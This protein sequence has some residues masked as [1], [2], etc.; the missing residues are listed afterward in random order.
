MVGKE[1]PGKSGYGAPALQSKVATSDSVGPPPPRRAGKQPRGNRGRPGP[2]VHG[3]GNEATPKRSRRADTGSCSVLAL[4]PKAEA[5]WG[6]AGARRPGG[7]GGG[8]QRRLGLNICRFLRLVGLHVVLINF[9]R[10]CLPSASVISWHT[11]GPAEASLPGDPHAE[12]SIQMSPSAGFMRKSGGAISLLSPSRHVMIPQS[13]L[14]SSI[15]S[16]T[17]SAMPS[18][19]RPFNLG[20]SPAMLAYKSSNTKQSCRWLKVSI[21]T[22]NHKGVTSSPARCKKDAVGTVPHRACIVLRFAFFATFLLGR[23][24]LKGVQSMQS[25]RRRIPLLLPGR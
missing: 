16:T 13:V 2:A 18:V 8:P 5:G 24:C 1:K 7:Q 22:H 20:P 21:R 12:P 11:A 6:R 19:A 9:E 4:M 14:V 25:G 10:I 15:G 17:R 23:T 3:G